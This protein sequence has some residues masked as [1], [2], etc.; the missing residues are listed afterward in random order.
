MSETVRRVADELAKAGWEQGMGRID[1]D[2]AEWVVRTVLQ[3]IR[4]PTDEMVRAA[5]PQ[6]IATAHGLGSGH[7]LHSPTLGGD[8]R[9]VFRGMIDAALAA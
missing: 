4:E 2:R 7:T 3:A 5:P 8:A 1:S 6:T 9:S